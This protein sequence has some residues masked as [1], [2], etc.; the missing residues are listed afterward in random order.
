MMVF[1]A[2]ESLSSRSI[3]QL[4]KG[5]ETNCTTTQNHPGNTRACSAHQGSLNLPFLNANSLKQTFL[6]KGFCFSQQ[7]VFALNPFIKLDKG[8]AAFP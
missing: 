8:K 7:P 1:T 2:Q 4:Q 6:P 3:P 5:Q